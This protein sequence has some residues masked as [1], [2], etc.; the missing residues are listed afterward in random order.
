MPA[1]Q[2]TVELRDAFLSEIIGGYLVQ[3]APFVVYKGP[4]VDALK[5]TAT[6]RLLLTSMR[7]HQWAKNLFVFAPLLFG[8]KLGEPGFV[9]RA[10]AATLSFCLLSSGMYLVNDIVD[11]EADRAHPEKRMRPIPSG[12]L[13]KSLALL[14]TLLLLTSAFVIGS[15][16]GVTFL[17]LE[18]AYCA[19]TL[20]YCL[21]FKQAI[22]LDG[23]L[24]ATG[25]VLRVVGG[26]VAVNVEASHWLIVCAFLL[27]LFLAFSKRRQELL[28]LSTD[29]EQHRSVLGQYTVGYLD[30]ANNIL[31][32]ATIV[33]YA[34]Y[35]VAPETIQKFG[36][37]KLIY[38][39]AFVIY[40]LLRY[41]A[42]LQD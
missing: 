36:T 13:S 4:S 8:M 34:L 11:A 33:C 2:D 25:F 18:T 1:R 17:L 37:D 42:L 19:V 22:V 41:L 26:A 9:L 10:L 5:G 40:G 21:T 14:T 24:I 29:A 32:A 35:T 15:A 39:S 12:A 23:M 27:A 38:G 16:L 6:L 20:G 31:L 7:P 28:I 30:R 3:Q